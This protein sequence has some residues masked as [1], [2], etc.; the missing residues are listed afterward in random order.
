MGPSSESLKIKFASFYLSRFSTMMARSAR[1]LEGPAR[2]LSVF[3]SGGYITCYKRYFTLPL[4]P[5]PASKCRGLYN[6]KRAAG[7]VATRWCKQAFAELKV[8]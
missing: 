8:C 7:A 2:K 3:R 6:K 5:S 1:Q 4:A